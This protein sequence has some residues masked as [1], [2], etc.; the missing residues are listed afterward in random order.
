MRV[1]RKRPTPFQADEMT[2][3][4]SRQSGVLVLGAWP[5]F[6]R[7]LSDME[8]FQRPTFLRDKLLLQLALVLISSS[9]QLVAQTTAFTYQG[10][11]LLNG[12]PASGSYDL[13]TAIYDASVNGGLLGSP[14]TNGTMAVSNGLFTVTLDFGAG[15][16]T[17]ASRWLDLAVRTKCVSINNIYNS[18]RPC[19]CGL[20]H[21][22]GSSYSREADASV[23]SS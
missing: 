22:Y 13:R 8:T 16:F 1:I 23:A 18:F 14:L 11:L 4:I 6:A 17:G 21:G 12:V 20:Q 5:G 19:Y 15:V 3:G 7:F 2:L 10:R 9:V